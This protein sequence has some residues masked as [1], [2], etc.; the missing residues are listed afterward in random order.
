MKHVNAKESKI[1]EGTTGPDDGKGI[2]GVAI[3]FWRL[4]F[5]GLRARL[6]YQ[7]PNWSN[8]LHEVTMLAFRIVQ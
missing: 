2:S 1:S 7:S 5:E 4:W 3:K 6:D 8:F